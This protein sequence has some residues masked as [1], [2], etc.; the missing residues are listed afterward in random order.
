VKIVMKALVLEKTKQL[1]L[2]DIAMPT[3]PGPNDVKIAMRNVG[4]CGSDVHFY[5]HGA[6]G[7][8]VVRQ[9]LVLGH[10]GAGEVVAVGQNVT[11]L[12]PGD[13]V[14]MEPG[15]PDW[16][17]RASRQGL[18]NLDPQVRFWACPPVHGCLAPEVVHPANLTFKLPDNVSCA[19]GAFV[20]PLAVGMQAA[21]KARITPGAIAVVLGSGTIGLATALSALAGGCAEVVITD[22]QQ[23]KL[24]LAARYPGLIPIN[25]A[26][27]DAVARV[28]EITGQWGADIVFEASGH[29]RA[30]DRLFDFA[31]PGGAVVLVGM[32]EKPVAYDVV[33][34]QAKE[35]RV[36]HVFRYANIYDRAVAL[37]GSGKIDV[38]PLI[39]RTFP[40]EKSVE[41]F[42]F[43][44][45]RR[46]EVIKTMIVFN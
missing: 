5:E 2:R 29:L 12:K 13:R 27:E 28:R 35:L 11:E 14:C 31:C 45:E 6:I 21:K 16:T 34:A 1:R 17:S 30:Y 32:P 26:K 18:Y 42:E 7:P 33:A 25:S 8:F 10:E 3:E 40:F 37:I 19:E 41:A 39:S 4:I 36:E 9:P 20:E 46:P 23:E 24:D 22:V 43:A 15:I 44:A 38:K